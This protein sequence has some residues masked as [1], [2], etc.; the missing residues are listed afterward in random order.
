MRHTQ[1]RKPLDLK[2]TRFF[3]ILVS[4]VLAARISIAEGGESSFFSTD[5]PGSLVVEAGLWDDTN[6]PTQGRYHHPLPISYIDP[7]ELPSDYFWGYVNGKSYLTRML[8]QHIPQYCGSCWAHASLSSLADR[9]K[10][11]RQA[12]GVDMEL[13]VQY[14]LNCGGNAGSCHGGSILRTYEWIYN[15]SFVPSETCMPYLACSAESTLG[16]CP[17]VDS[18]CSPMNTCRTCTPDGICSALDYFPNATI[19]EYGGYRY[20]V[21]AVKAEIFARGPVGA[22]VAGQPLREYHGGIYDNTTAPTKTTHAVSIVGWGTEKQ[23]G[24][25]YWIVRNS[26]GSYAGENG[27]FRILMG[28][29]VLGIESHVVWATPGIF[30][31][32]TFPCNAG[33]F[34]CVVS[35]HY[36]DPSMHLS[37]IQRRLS[38]SVGVR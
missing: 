20:S 31:E 15:N 35:T 22:G 26:W 32:A 12:Q 17:Y 18:V 37:S 30:T 23:T 16:F 6:W 1:T 2:E 4:L 21:E 5:Q 25:Q 10:I 13:S 38:E 28:H 29:N 36:D 3:Y 24:R 11:A 8:N 14:I 19:A 34:S 9:I 27:F 7:K 33:L